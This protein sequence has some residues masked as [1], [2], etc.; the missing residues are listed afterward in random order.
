MENEAE[1]SPDPRPLVLK[2][3]AWDV[4]P[5]DYDAIREVQGR[6]GLVPD[7]D[8]GMD[9]EHAA[10]DARVNR[11]APLQ[12]TLDVLSEFAGEV[13]AHYMLLTVSAEAGDGVEVPQEIIDVFQEQ[14]AEVLSEGVSAIVSHLMDTG[15]LE[16]GAKIKKMLGASGE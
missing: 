10:S 15:I 1:L 8:E 3:L 12:E 5:H 2:R 16:Y 11:I 14:N 9:V 13:L 7:D 4:F 6:L